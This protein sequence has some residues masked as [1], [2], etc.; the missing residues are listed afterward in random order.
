MFLDSLLHMVPGKLSQELCSIAA[1]VKAPLSK[2]TA[3]EGSMDQLYG[4]LTLLH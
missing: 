1:Q 2:T 4:Q 3:T